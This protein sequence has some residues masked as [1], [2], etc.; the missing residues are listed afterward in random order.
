MSFWL[1]TF[2]LEQRN[3]IARCSDQFNPILTM[4]DLPIELIQKKPAK[5]I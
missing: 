2:I 4:Q 5:H 1:P 3:A